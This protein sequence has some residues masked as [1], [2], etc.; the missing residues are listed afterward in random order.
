MYKYFYK[1]GII[2]M[3]FY[4]MIEYF[5]VLLYYLYLFRIFNF[6]YRSYTSKGG[7]YAQKTSHDRLFG[8]GARRWI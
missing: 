3:V 4:F 1:L 7:Q 8:H 2:L 6:W 5:L